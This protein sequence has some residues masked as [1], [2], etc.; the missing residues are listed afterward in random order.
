MYNVVIYDIIRLKLF[1]ERNVIWTRAMMQ[2]RWSGQPYEY[3]YIFT[4]PSSY[5]YNIVVKQ[6]ND[7][8]VGAIGAVAIL[9]YH[10][11]WNPICKFISAKLIH[12]TG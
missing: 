4:L 10:L 5:Q 8:T 6:L 11:L 9:Y 1:K 7:V 3:E 2:D 12:V